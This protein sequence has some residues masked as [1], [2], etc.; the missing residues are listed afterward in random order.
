M[1]GKRNAKRYREGSPP[2]GKLFFIGDRVAHGDE[3]E[4]VMMVVDFAEP[5]LLGRKQVVCGWHN[6]NAGLSP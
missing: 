2:P 6:A 3:P 1:S 4:H 5:D